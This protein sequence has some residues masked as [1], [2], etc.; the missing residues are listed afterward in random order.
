[1]E[2]LVGLGCDPD[3]DSDAQESREEGG[4]GSRQEERGDSMCYLCTAPSYISR[5][6]SG[7]HTHIYMCVRVRVCERNG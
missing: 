1:M 7:G 6:A 5:P 4:R 3:S 2:S